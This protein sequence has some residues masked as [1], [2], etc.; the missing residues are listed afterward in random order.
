MARNRKKSRV[1]KTPKINQKA[2]K[3]REEIL[4]EGIIPED[5]KD[6]SQLNAFCQFMANLEERR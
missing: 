3:I 1:D 4:K 6:L 2:F 5:E